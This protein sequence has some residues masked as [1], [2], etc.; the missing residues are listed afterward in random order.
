MPAAFAPWA[1]TAA[2]LAA[3]R[4]GRAACA[5]V[6][7]TASRRGVAS[8]SGRAHA[9]AAGAS[10]APPRSGGAF[11]CLPIID[12]SPLLDPPPGGPA[13]RSFA[14][15]AAALHAAARDVGFF[16]ASGL[17]GV[18]DGVP[19]LLSS[20][21]AWFARPEADKARIALS[22]ATHFR[23]WQPLGANVT[24][25]GP[26]GDSSAAGF[27]RDAHE[28]F[29]LYFEPR[30]DRAA[31]VAPAPPGPPL[32][33]SPLHGPNPW[34]ADA[35][36]LVAG[37][38]AHIAA[39]LDVGQA[40]TRGLAAGLGLPPHYFEGPGGGW[41]GA[42]SSYY[43]LRAISYPP[44]PPAAA[45]AVAAAKRTG[46]DL[47]PDL[48]LSCGSHTDYGL[49]TLV[50]ADEPG[51][52]VRNAAGA[53]VGAPPLAGGF[54]VNTGDMWRLWSA[55]E[56][57]P[58]LHR[59]VYTGHEGE[60]GRNGGG[61]GGGHGGRP[62]LPPRTS[63]AFFYEPAFDAVC[64]APPSLPGAAAMGDEAVDYGRHLERKVLSNFE[65]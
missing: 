17:E 24:R 21:A 41:T 7:G 12:V 46:G 11:K 32:R 31:A 63:I 15:T 5:A 25:Y 60:A 10:D 56:Y 45:A 6:N 54:V 29:D 48:G 34:P 8:V 40:I 37:L 42:H 27:V 20:A 33:P 58:T 52:E 4:A 13:S 18:T 35:P 2:A 9:D 44:L 22:P 30:C 55:G 39:C 28:G 49:L 65:L 43:V 36:E 57:Q 64:R 1:A 47:P 19:G 51:L 3:A 26:A 62:H 61:D 23:G 53:W 38:K 14:G 16:Y 59:V 50:A